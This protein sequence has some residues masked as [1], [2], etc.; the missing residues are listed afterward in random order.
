MLHALP[1]LD[2]GPSLADLQSTA[3]ILVQSW[4]DAMG[5]KPRPYYSQRVLT[6]LQEGF[7]PEVILA[8]MQATFEAPDPSWR[9]LEAIMRRCATEGC[10]QP[11]Q[12][13]NRRPPRTAL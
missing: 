3:R 13:V 4:Y 5:G 1:I 10:Y 9:Y 11:M 2:K 6:W 7:D 8:A 12:W